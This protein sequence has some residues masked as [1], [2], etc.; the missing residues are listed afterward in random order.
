MSLSLFLPLS[1]CR[2]DKLQDANEWLEGEALD[3]ALEEA[4]RDCPDLLRL[5]SS[6]DMNRED[7]FEEYETLKETCRED[8]D[9]LRLLRDST[10]NLK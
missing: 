9:Y 4:T 10:K 3:A 5:V 7:L 1:L 8:E 2:K 6:N